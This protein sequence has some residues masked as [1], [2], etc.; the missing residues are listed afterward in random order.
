MV[1]KSKSIGEE[2]FFL[3]KLGTLPRYRNEDS[4]LPSHH[5]TV[6]KGAGCE[7]FPRWNMLLFRA[8]CRHLTAKHKCVVQDKKGVHV[9]IYS[10]WHF[11]FQKETYICI[12]TCA[13]VYVVTK[14]LFVGPSPSPG[15]KLGPDEDLCWLRWLLAGLCHPSSV[16]RQRYQPCCTCVLDIHHHFVFSVLHFTLE[17]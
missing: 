13:P 7:K 5:A 1:I 16:T 9:L 3:V 8:L 12:C 11:A 14:T 6:I 10:G 15:P 4:L 2:L 17:I